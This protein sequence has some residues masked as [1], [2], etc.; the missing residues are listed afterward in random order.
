MIA[1][2]QLAAHPQATRRMQMPHMR[3]YG[4]HKSTIAV[5]VAGH[6]D[7]DAGDNVSAQLWKLAEDGDPRIVVCADQL[8][9]R[10][11]SGFRCLAQSIQNLRELGRDI[12]ISVTSAPLRAVLE[13]LLLSDACV[14]GQATLKVDRH[15]F[16]RN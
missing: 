1:P 4:T 7:A 3:Q 12:V 10:N 2:T 15:V 16:V 13:D 14:F 11:F 6:L 8:R 9:L 5:H